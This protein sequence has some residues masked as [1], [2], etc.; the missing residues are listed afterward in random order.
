MISFD[1]FTENKGQE[2]NVS[3][4]FIIRLTPKTYVYCQQDEYDS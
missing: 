2:G 4:I 3:L 1:I